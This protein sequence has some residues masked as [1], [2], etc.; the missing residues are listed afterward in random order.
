MNKKSFLRDTLIFI[1]SAIII[2]ISI[3]CLGNN[4]LMVGITGLFLFIA[5]LNKDFS[6]TPLRGII[7]ISFLMGLIAFVPYLANLNIYTGLVI[8][9]L[10]IFFILYIVVYTLNKTIYFPFVFGYTLFLTTDVSGRNLALRIIG[11][12]I[13]GIIAVIFQ[14]LYTKYTSEKSNENKIL[15]E[16][17]EALVS[18]INDIK[19]GKSN[20]KSRERIKE[21]STYW[22]R[23][24]LEKR[25][26]S[27]YLNEDENIELNLI[28]TIERLDRLSQK[29]GVKLNTGEDKYEE[30]LS[31]MED[32]LNSLKNFI[33]KKID[34]KEL[35][36]SID[37]MNL[38][39]KHE[40]LNDIIIYEAI[41]ALA[42]IDKLTD[43]LLVVNSK[44]YVGYKFGWKEIVETKNLLVSDFN[45]NSVRFI[46]AFRTALIVS[47]SYFA[48]EYF[49]IQLAKWVIFTITSV[50]QPYNDTIRSRAKGRIIGTLIGVV[51]YLPLASVFTTVDERLVII[52]I[53]AYLMILFKEYSYS[54][55]ML[56]VLFLGVI[57]IDV[58]N[59]MAY[60]EDRLFFVAL[61]VIIVLLANRFIFPYSLRKETKALVEKYYNTGNEIIEKTMLLYKKKNVKDD[62]IN[63]ILEAQGFEN[64]ILLNNVALDNDLLREFRN[65]QRILLNNV[66]TILNRV[67][68]CEI[69]LKESME[70]KLKNLNSMRDE[71]E[72]ELEVNNLDTENIL[73]RYCN[74]AHN[75][76]EKL[77]YIDVYEMIVA[78]YKC[79]R[80]KDHLMATI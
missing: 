50:S 53:A 71:I 54:T 36:K 29:I 69:N 66:N 63:L 27:F 40:K 4:N 77:I 37:K 58:Q 15:T 46:F 31:H 23:D 67:E 20:L 22:S 2:I 5:I 10:A 21:L 14:I 51:I 55:A 74:L 30:L 65:N 24:I 49:H 61:G 18:S 35:N 38:A 79:A 72:K 59:I 60:V 52:G 62:I 32:L 78:K 48:M 7:K 16:M 41:E 47:L 9:F 8:N 56:T 44:K 70:G 19:I 76:T 75:T 42:V 17:I 68:Y 57:T 80:I 64:K 28:A 12:I 1:L 26:N 34:I 33:N 13:V 39:Y 3:K 11:L 45:R 73:N 6:R 25:N 43:A